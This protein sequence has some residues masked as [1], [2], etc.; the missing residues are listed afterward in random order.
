MNTNRNAHPVLYALIQLM[1]ALVFPH[2]AIG[3]TT[4]SRRSR[5]RR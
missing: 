1:F 4:H 5:R 3:T 2:H